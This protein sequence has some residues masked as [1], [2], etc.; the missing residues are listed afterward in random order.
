M[1]TWKVVLWDGETQTTWNILAEDCQTA[2]QKARIK[3]RVTYC[4]IGKVKSCEKTCC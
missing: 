4:K 2:V 3:H 1:K